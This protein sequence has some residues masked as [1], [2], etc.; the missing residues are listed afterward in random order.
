VDFSVDYFALRGSEVQIVLDVAKAAGYQH[1]KNAN[2]S[3]S[4]MFYQ[5]LARKK[6]C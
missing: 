1:R 2:G 3:K 6:G 5:Y 4:L